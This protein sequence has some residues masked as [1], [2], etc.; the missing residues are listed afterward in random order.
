MA[1]IYFRPA[2]VASF[3]KVAIADL[4]DQTV[5]LGDLWGARPRRWCAG[6]AW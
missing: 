3:L 5:D 4:T 2:R 6:G 1:G